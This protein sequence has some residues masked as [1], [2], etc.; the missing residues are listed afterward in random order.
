M[1]PRNAEERPGQDAHTASKTS[2]S[3]RHGKSTTRSR[4][5]CVADRP[6]SITYVAAP[7]R[8][9]HT[10]AVLC[11]T[12]SRWHLHRATHLNP[13]VRRPMCGGPRYRVIPAVAAARIPGPRAAAQLEQGA[14]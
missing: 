8:S 10:H 12:C 4:A 3:P 9:T 2:R 1:S 6:A 11:N 14:A 7:D 13:V 5:R